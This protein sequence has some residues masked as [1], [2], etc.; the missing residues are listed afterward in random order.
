MDEEQIRAIPTSELERFLQTL[1]YRDREIFKLAFG[2]GDGY[3]YT[4]NEIGHIFKTPAQ[5]I[6]DSVDASVARLAD[7]LRARRKDELSSTSAD[8]GI[9]VSLA[10]PEFYD[11]DFVVQRL[12]ELCEALNDMHF[13]LGGSGLTVDDDQS[14]TEVVTL[15]G[16]PR[17]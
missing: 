17:S 16:A 5:N 12:V 9:L 6:R 4:Q 3:R 15:T 1:P 8:D 13:G 2:L 7:Y 11:E 10:F 14:R